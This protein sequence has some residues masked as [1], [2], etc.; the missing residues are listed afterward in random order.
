VGDILDD[1]GGLGRKYSIDLLPTTREKI[2]K[3]KINAG[4]GSVI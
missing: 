4:I 1:D 3:T 2:K